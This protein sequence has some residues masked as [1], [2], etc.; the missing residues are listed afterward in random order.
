MA[1]SSDPANVNPTPIF[2][3]PGNDALVGT[4]GADQIFGLG[5]TDVLIGGEGDDS[6][7]AGAPGAG[8]IGSVLLGGNGNDMLNGG[9]GGNV[10]DGGNGDD[11]LNG[12]GAPDILLGGDG[13]D[14]LAGGPGADLMTGGNGADTF[15]Y[16]SDPFDGATPSAPVQGQIPGVNNPDT[17][18]DFTVADDR[19][20]LDVNSLGL[21]AFSF[22]NG[23]VNDLSGNANVLVLQGEFANARVAAQAVADNNDLTGGAGV[24]IYHNAT[25]GF[26]R[27]VYSSDLSG[28]GAF[29]VLA[30]LTSQTGDAG[31][32]LLPSYT[33]Q[34]FSV[35]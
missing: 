8:G 21:Q 34:N 19:F 14:T 29:S 6:L 10:L 28:G 24:F 3:T 31:T 22:A 16:N 13:N 23:A 15:L 20:S 27:L 4:D 12:G 1:T 32:A 2:G 26:N 18:T 7:S 33:A 5:G 11:T 30:N 25:L 9:S 17:I 35:V